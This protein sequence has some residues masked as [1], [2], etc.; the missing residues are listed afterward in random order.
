M[1]PT[2]QRPTRKTGLL[3][4]KVHSGRIGDSAITRRYAR[5]NEGKELIPTR[6]N[7][8]KE[9][10][11]STRNAEKE[12]LPQLLPRAL[13]MS[14]GWRE[15]STRPMQKSR[16]TMDSRTKDRAS[17]Q[18]AIHPRRPKQAKALLAIHV[19]NLEQ[20]RAK[21]VQDGTTKRL[22]A[23]QFN[24]DHIVEDVR[25]AN[26]IP[27]RS[28]R[29]DLGLD[30]SVRRHRKLE[31][32]IVV[33]FWGYA[34]I[35]T[36]VKI[37][38]LSV[39]RFADPLDLARLILANT[40]VRKAAAQIGVDIDTTTLVGY[41]LQYPK[42]YRYTKRNTIDLAQEQL[43]PFEVVRSEQHVIV[44]TECAL[45]EFYWQAEHYACDEHGSVLVQV[46]GRIGMTRVQTS[47]SACVE[48]FDVDWRN[49]EEKRLAMEARRQYLEKQSFISG[50]EKKTLE[51]KMKAIEERSRMAVENANAQKKELGIIIGR[52]GQEAEAIYQMSHI[53]TQCDESTFSYNDADDIGSEIDLDLD[54]DLDIA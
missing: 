42:G 54:L 43:M 39:E 27:Y 3:S 18:V 46:I 34:P 47:G 10:F 15:E 51:E 38:S 8:H 26:T 13:K 33:G 11:P 17:G 21:Q 7:A 40:D 4:D 20:R 19:A 35:F 6:S 48:S 45:R 49:D 24:P 1:A 31:F 23:M 14:A 41:E 37:F 50:A 16:T 32:S 9:L 53:T 29:L 5:K 52:Q 28:V 12:L 30:T 2:N 25:E 44:N 36:P 22:Q